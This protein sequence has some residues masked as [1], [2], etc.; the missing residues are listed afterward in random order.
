LATISGGSAVFFGIKTSSSGTLPSHTIAGQMTAMEY[1]MDFGM[2]NVEIH[3]VGLRMKLQEGLVGLGLT[4]LG[5]MNSEVTS[6]MLTFGL[7]DD[8]E[9]KRFANL[10]WIE[11]GLVLED[12]RAGAIPKRVAGRRTFER[13]ARV[14]SRVQ[15]RGGCGQTAGGVEGVINERLK[16]F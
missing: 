3:N 15:H 14:F 16:F 6:H 5:A 4:V 2:E 1:L 11:H 7:P 13:S 8:K 12:H 9:A 10:L